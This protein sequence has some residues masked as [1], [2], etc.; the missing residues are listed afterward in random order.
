MNRLII[1]YLIIQIP[2]L[3]FCQPFTNGWI[4]YSKQYYKVQ[5]TEEG[6]YRIEVNE[7]LN[8]GIPTGS[9]NPQGI[10]LFFQGVEQYI[11]VEGEGN[12]VFDAGEYIEFYGKGNDGWLDR[13]SGLLLRAVDGGHFLCLDVIIVLSGRDKC[14][15][16]IY[17]ETFRPRAPPAMSTPSS[18]LT[19]PIHLLEPAL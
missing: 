4:D 1:I 12:G 7:L 8:A 11:Y 5:I 13:V 14:T 9:I 17:F 3:T 15:I 6:I 2:A 10:Q 19:L 18:V 16:Q